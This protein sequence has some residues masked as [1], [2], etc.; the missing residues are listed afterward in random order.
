M[1][2][3]FTLK[4]SYTCT[5]NSAMLADNDIHEQQHFK[6]TKGGGSASCVVFAANSQIRATARKAAIKTKDCV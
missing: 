5:V 2:A 4:L 3:E 1:D 6:T